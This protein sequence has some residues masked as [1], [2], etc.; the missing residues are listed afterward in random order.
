MSIFP[1]Y[2]PQNTKEPITKPEPSQP[3]YGNFTA[4]DKRKSVKFLLE[5]FSGKVQKLKTI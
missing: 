3:Y 2:K 1:G 5:N 4:K